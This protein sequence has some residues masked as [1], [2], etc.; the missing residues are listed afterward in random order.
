MIATTPA[1]QRIAR[2]ILCEL[3]DYVRLAKK[4]YQHSWVLLGEAE[5]MLDEAVDNGAS[6]EIRNLLADNVDAAEAIKHD[7]WVDMNNA[8]ALLLSMW[9]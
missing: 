3:Q 6:R 4:A 9:N 7:A 5:D 1:I 2:P 8:E